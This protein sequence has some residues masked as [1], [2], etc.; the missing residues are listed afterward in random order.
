MTLSGFR[1]A[2]RRGHLDR[3]KRI[4]G[5]LAKMRHAAIRVCTDEPDYS[6]I[7]DFEHDWSKTVYGELKEIKPDDAPAPLGRFVT[8]TH[9]VDATL[10]H[11]VISG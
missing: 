2:P 10:M 11:D 5:Y 4:Y 6:D 1:I 3:V 9:Y 8:S 7:P